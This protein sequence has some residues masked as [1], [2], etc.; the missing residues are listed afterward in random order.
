MVLRSESEG[1]QRGGGRVPARS[2]STRG[3]SRR[4]LTAVPGIHHLFPRTET[5]MPRTDWQPC[6]YILANAHRTL[7]IGVTNNVWRRVWEHRQSGGN[8]FTHRHDIHRLVYMAHFE[9]MD[10]AIVW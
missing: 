3:R 9:R 2:A 5:T 1:S 7:Y 6:V 10:D 8:A 4:I